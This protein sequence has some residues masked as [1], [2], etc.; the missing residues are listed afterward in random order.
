MSSYE[1]W[2]RKLFEDLARIQRIQNSSRF[3]QGAEELLR[4]WQRMMVNAP[5]IP[6]LPKDLTISIPVERLALSDHVVASFVDETERLRPVFEKF[7][8]ELETAPDE[9]AKRLTLDQ[10]ARAIFEGAT[11]REWRVDTPVARLKLVAFIVT[12]LTVFVLGKWSEA[13]QNQ[14]LDGIHDLLRDQVQVTATVAESVRQIQLVQEQQQRQQSAL[15]KLPLLRVAN[16]G[17]LREGPSPKTQRIKVVSP[18]DTLE[19]IVRV[20]RWYFVEVLAEN[21]E[22]TGLRGW[23]YRRNVRRVQ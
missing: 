2:L 10:A 22:R 4:E 19:E 5:A 17:N 6:P 16:T 7:W 15:P 21:G 14:K 18:G 9:P 23:V 12:A 3:A 11:G 13:E 8:T 1:K 20:D